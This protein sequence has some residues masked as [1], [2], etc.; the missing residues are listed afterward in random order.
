MPL[1][2]ICKGQN[3]HKLQITFSKILMSLNLQGLFT[4]FVGADSLETKKYVQKHDSAVSQ[5]VRF[6]YHHFYFT[7]YFVQKAKRASCFCL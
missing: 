1:C 3:A 2:D 4:P 6:A 7:S 5:E